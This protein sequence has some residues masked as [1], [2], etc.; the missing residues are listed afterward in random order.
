MMATV[1]PSLLR[2]LSLN[3]YTWLHKKKTQEV[4]YD[5]E[6]DYFF[7]SK[8]AQ[9]SILTAKIYQHKLMIMMMT[10]NVSFLHDNLFMWL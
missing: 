1:L 10:R 8:E 9:V 7:L 5:Q 2:L 4:K 6:Q 3:P